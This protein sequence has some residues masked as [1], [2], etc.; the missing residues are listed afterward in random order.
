MV[1][2]IQWNAEAFKFVTKVFGYFCRSYVCFFKEKMD[3]LWDS[4]HLVPIAQSNFIFS[5]R[6]MCS[7][8]GPPELNVYFELADTRNRSGTIGTL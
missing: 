2:T 5:L 8:K 6:N 3:F 1:S 4:L 7:L